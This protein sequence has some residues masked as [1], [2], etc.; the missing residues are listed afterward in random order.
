VIVNARL[1][2][3][4]RLLA[5]GLADRSL[6]E[7]LDGSYQTAAATARSSLEHAQRGDAVATPHTA[8][9]HLVMAWAAAHELDL[10]AAHEQL[11]AAAAE[12][13]LQTAP[14]LADLVRLLEV[15]LLAEEGLVG[16][17]RRL[18]A[19]HRPPLSTEPGFLRR[20]AVIS[21]AQIAAMTNDVTAMRDQV[22]VLFELGQPRDAELFGAIALA[23]EGRLDDALDR[24]DAL[25]ERPRLHAA[26][27]ASAAAVRLGLL[28]QSR[29]MP[30]A[31]ELLPDLL[32]RVAPQRM[33]QI[34]SAGAIGGAAF[35]R[36]LEAEADRPDGHPFAAEALACLGRYARPI[37][38]LG[39]RVI[40][41]GV[42]Q[43]T[44]R[45]RDVLAELALGGSYGDVARALFLS[46]NTVKTH[47]AS[48]YRKLGVDRRVD[49]LRVARDHHLL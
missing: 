38:E 32:N 16:D 14:V 17:A 13:A 36:L 30:R 9:A 39:P 41:D 48:V 46:E 1:L 29:Q 5:A 8:G 42:D 27:S 12:P 19:Q 21:A 24:I 35:T 7:L 47:L 44:P 23:C 2:G 43:L 20:L 40:D 22:S 45:E 49:A 11:A 28:V 26:V 33:L 3:S 10:I 4:E 6:L 37:R 15:K 25:L 31:A 18:L 34:L